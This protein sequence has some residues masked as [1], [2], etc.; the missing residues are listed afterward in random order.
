M[1]PDRAPARNRENR[2]KSRTNALRLSR[3]PRLSRREILALGACAFGSIPLAADGDQSFQVTAG[4]SIIDVTF[5]PGSFDLGPP[6][7]LGWISVA[8]RGASTYY[9]KFPVLA[10]SVR[11]R[12]VEGRAGV[13]RGTTYG[14]GPRTVMGLGQHST[15]RQLD[16]DWTMTHEFLHLGF[17]SMRRQ[18]HWIEEGIAVYAEPVARA[19]IGTVTVQQVWGDMMRDMHQ[20][21][22]GPG[23][24]G[25]DGTH[26]WGRTYWG[27]AIFCLLADVRIR[28]RTS[29]RVGLQHALRGI[30][31]AGGT[32]EYDWSI[33]DAF[34]AGDAAVKVP[35]LAELYGQMKDKPVV[36]DLDQLWRR[37][38]VEASGGSV[39]FH[40]DAPLAAIRQAITKPLG[41]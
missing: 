39:V 10:V 30:L 5:T 31:A 11:I 15:R 6:A 29:N 33:E 19:Q 40:A 38:G 37:L 23:D 21:Q 35:V 8:A 14:D 36:T 22:P 7:I 27:G 20:G 18:H 32:I 3:R 16:D 13:L 24:R 1:A 26:T 2:M 4:E 41:S 17:P 34:A 25:L 12:A 28:E 9:G